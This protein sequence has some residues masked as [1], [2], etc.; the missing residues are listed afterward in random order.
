MDK[1]NKSANLFDRLAIAFLSAILAFITG[2]IIWV[3]VIFLSHGAFFDFYSG[4]FRIVLY[5]T[6]LMAVLGF[7]MMQNILID[8]F[9]VVWKYVFKV[10]S[11]IS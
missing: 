7:L 9:G 5:F 1:N 4:A 2:I 11:N 3:V 8:L 6:G 10:L